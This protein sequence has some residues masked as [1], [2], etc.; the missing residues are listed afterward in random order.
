MGVLFLRLMFPS[1]IT[2]TSAHRIAFGSFF[3]WD[4]V[5]FIGSFGPFPT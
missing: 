5:G 4:V 2:F 3:G 1:V